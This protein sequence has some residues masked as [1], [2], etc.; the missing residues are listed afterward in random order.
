MRSDSQEATQMRR[1]GFTRMLALST[2]TV[3]LAAC[4]GGGGGGG[5]GETTA[6][7]PSGGNTGGGGNPATPPPTGGSNTATVSVGQGSFSPANV[8]VGVNG[9]V[10]WNWGEC[11]NN[12]PYYGNTC[13]MHSVTF[14]DAGMGGSG[15]QDK[16]SYQKTFAAK[17]TFKY[18]CAVHGSSMS[19]AVTVQ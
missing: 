16:G 7:P 3:V 2:L 15:N 19:G 18:H 9:T 4:G 10:T 12:D 13:V 6:P 5:G 17:G 1:T 8:T 11:S 14:D